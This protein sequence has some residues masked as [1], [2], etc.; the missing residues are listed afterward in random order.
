[1]HYNPDIGKACPYTK[2][3]Q[4]NQ[5]INADQVSHEVQHPAVDLE[6]ILWDAAWMQPDRRKERK[7]L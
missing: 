6:K 5:L 2:Y 4:G 3:T 7:V 1:M